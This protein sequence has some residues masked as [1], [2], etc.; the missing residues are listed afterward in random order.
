M[1]NITSRLNRRE[2]LKAISA[3]CLTPALI[4]NVF[5]ETPVETADV[6]GHLSEL[7]KNAPLTMQFTGDTEEVC[8]A[9]QTAFAE[10]LRSLLGPHKPPASWKTT[11]ERSVA[12]KDH[13]RD[14][15]ILTA[16]GHPALPIHLLVPHH[17]GT[18]PLP[19]IVALHGHGRFGHDAVVGKTEP[20]EIAQEIEKLNYDYGLE[21]VRKGYVVA[22]PCLTPF[23][24]R[25]ADPDAYRGRD[26]C[27]VTLVR[28]QFLG[29]LPMA[30]NLRDAMWA[31]NLLAAQDNVDPNRIGCV[32]LSYGG[33]M[34]ML[35]TALDSRIRVA[36]ISGALNVMQE[37]IAQ[38]FSCGAQVIPG[39]LQYGDVP[40]IASLIAPRPC[41]WE[42]GTKDGLISK[43][44]ANAAMDRIRHAY[45]AYDAESQVCVSWFDGG[46]RFDGR[47]SYPLLDKHLLL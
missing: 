12:L 1:K 16:T 27:A 34:T 32:G 17:A 25:L 4:R 46:H 26:P 11:L 21:L 36:V 45:R 18:K 31:V 8:R 29:K 19:A 13:R 33:R 15:L 38:R 47:E 30:E 14:E 20:P 2:T 23:G 44:W 3:S 35:T 43:P 41:I 22:A 40:E 6:H 5:A 28:M 39:L 9:W 37:R 42:A 7:A 24:R 10:K